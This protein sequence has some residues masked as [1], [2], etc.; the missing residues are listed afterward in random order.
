MINKSKKK[1]KIKKKKG[2]NKRDSTKNTK[3]FSLLFIIINLVKLCFY[4]MIS[5][6]QY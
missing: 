5:F 2:K 3:T 1:K 4:S 6:K